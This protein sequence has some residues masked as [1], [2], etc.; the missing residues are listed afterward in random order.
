MI[1]VCAYQAGPVVSVHMPRD[2][3][4][5]RSQGFGF[6]EFRHEI[7]AEYAIK[8]MHM[9]KLFGNPLRVNKSSQNKDSQNIGAN[10]FIGGLHPDVDEKLLYDTFSAFGGIIFT[11]KVRKA[12]RSHRP[13]LVLLGSKALWWSFADCTPS[14]FGCCFRV[15]LSPSPTDHARRNR[16]LQRLRVCVV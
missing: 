10:L 3:V 15:H 8:V 7:D 6:V 5:N 13:S 4:T 2:K 14:S 9:I 1:N 11:P 12:V 16:N